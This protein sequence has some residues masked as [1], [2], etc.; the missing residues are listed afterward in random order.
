MLK[1][2]TRCTE[3][4]NIELI[5]K[6]LCQLLV[7]PFLS[8]QFKFSVHSYILINLCCLIPF[9][10]YQSNLLLLLDWSVQDTC[11][12]SL[13][14]W[15]FLYIISRYLLQSPDN[16]NSFWFPQKAPVI[17]SRLYLNK[18]SPLTTGLPCPTH[19]NKFTPSAVVFL[20]HVLF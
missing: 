10:K 20:I 17:R 11:I 14:I 2:K 18:P 3:V 12:P 1:K 6:Q 5:S 8:L 15:L 19:S 7:F 16:S 13:S 9:S 4:W